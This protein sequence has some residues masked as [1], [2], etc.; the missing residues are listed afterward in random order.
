MRHLPTWID[1]VIVFELPLKLGFRGL[2]R[3][4]GMLVH[5]QAGWAEWS[6]FCEYGAGEAATWLAATKES[7]TCDDPELVRTEIAV[8]AIVPAV[9]P[10]IAADIAA[11]S[12]CRTVKVKVAQKGQQLADDCARVAAVREALGAEGRVRVDANGAWSLDEAIVALQALEPYGLEY[13]E[14]PCRDV[15]ELAALHSRLAADRI[16]IKI[17]ADESIRRDDDPRRVKELQAADLMVVK[18]QPLG[19]IGRAHQIINQVDL[20]V[21]VSSALETSVGLRQGLLLAATLPK[22]EYDCGLNTMPLFAADVTSTT[23]TSRNGMMTVPARISPD[24]VKEYQLGGTRE[25]W[26]HDRLITAAAI[27]EEKYQS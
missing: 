15:N 27:M 19:G 20:P 7:A 3:R 25:L 22:L 17:A 16:A 8:N 4:E 13:V 1:D 10:D 12:K 5:G 18:C 23:I 26:W 14:Q 24:K 9:S 11:S 21:V 2:Q 6:P